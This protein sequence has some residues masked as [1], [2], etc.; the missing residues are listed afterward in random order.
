MGTVYIKNGSE[1]DAGNE[2]LCGYIIIKHKTVSCSV[3]NCIIY[4]FHPRAK[5]FGGGARIEC[6]F[7]KESPVSL[8]SKTTWDRKETIN[9]IPVLLY[10]LLSTTVTSILPFSRHLQHSCPRSK[11]NIT[12]WIIISRHAQS[13][14]RYNVTMSERNWSKSLFWQI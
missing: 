13:A 7:L 9:G 8:L 12:Q 11:S 6:C 1:T 4:I 2:W 3:D 5:C 14:C 10:P